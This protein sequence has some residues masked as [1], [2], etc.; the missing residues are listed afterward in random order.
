TTL[1]FSFAVLTLTNNVANTINTKLDTMSKSGS[2]DI[3][4]ISKE[5][6]YREERRVIKNLI[7]AASIFQIF[8]WLTYS[9]LLSGTNSE[10]C[11]QCIFITNMFVFWVFSLLGFL[12]AVFNPRQNLFSGNWD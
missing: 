5:I 10:M 11:F 7:L 4:V 8:N 12:K 9:I 6:G 2:F 1:A 3:K